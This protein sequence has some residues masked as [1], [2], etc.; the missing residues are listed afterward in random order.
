M[1]YFVAKAKCGSK[2]VA[3]LSAE[4]KLGNCILFPFGFFFNL[5]KK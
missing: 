5:Y 1:R 3:K 2:L 4:N